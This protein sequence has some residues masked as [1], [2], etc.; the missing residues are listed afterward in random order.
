VAVVAILAFSRLN[1]RLSPLILV[2]LGMD[3]YRGCALMAISGLIVTAYLVMQENAAAHSAANERPDRRRFSQTS[4]YLILLFAISLTPFPASRRNEG[5]VSV[6]RCGLQRPI[7]ANPHG[8]PQRGFSAAGPAT[9][10]GRP[11]R[12]RLRCDRTAGGLKAGAAGDKN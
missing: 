4:N 1:G 3:W 12:Q 6:S 8:V 7:A 11:I 9:I 5:R 10:K 2:G